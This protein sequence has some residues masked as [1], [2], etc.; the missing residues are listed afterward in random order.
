MCSCS[1]SVCYILADPEYTILRFNP[2]NYINKHTSGKETMGS[3]WMSLLD[4][5]SSLPSS[6]SFREAVAVVVKTA[7]PA[8]AQE[9]FES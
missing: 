4:T 9:K 6:A 5:S 3:K 8:L 1:L 2:W 7:A